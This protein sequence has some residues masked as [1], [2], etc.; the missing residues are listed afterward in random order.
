M[1]F[2][3]PKNI[4][5]TFL[6]LLFCDF[7]ASAQVKDVELGINGLTCSQCSRSV[8]MKLRRLDFVKDVQ[9]N[10]ERTEGKIT[11]RPDKKVDMERVA[12]AVED[13]GFSVRY[14]QATFNFNQVQI[15]PGHCFVYSGDNYQFLQTPEKVLDGLVTITF[16]GPKYQAKKDAKKYQPYMQG[17]CDAGGKLYYV[18]L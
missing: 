12:K 2:P 13:A 14:L 9:M 10:L 15:T 17:G 3:S 8:E 16:V 11:L 5:L 18:T 6:V 7:A 4:L 1:K